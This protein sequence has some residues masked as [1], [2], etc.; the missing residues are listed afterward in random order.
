MPKRTPSTAVTPA[1]L[2]S[3]EQ[4]GVTFRSDA[5]GHYADIR[6]LNLTYGPFDSSLMARQCAVL[7]GHHLVMHELSGKAAR[8]ADPLPAL[9]PDWQPLGRVGEAA[10]WACRNVA[11]VTL[12]RA[13]LPGAMLTGVNGAPIEVRKGADDS[14]L[15]PAIRAGLFRE[16]ERI[17]M[18][19]APTRPEST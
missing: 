12:V 14:A 8:I 10:I 3:L 5:R 19:Y 13:F 6:A 1:Q 11:G 18:H 2:A 9:T 4:N 15:N 17:V 16:M 7:N